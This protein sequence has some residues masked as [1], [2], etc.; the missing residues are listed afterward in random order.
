[1]A[2]TVSTDLS[3]FI[4]EECGENVYECYQCER[5][6]SGCPTVSAMRYRPAQMMRLAQFGMEQVLEGKI[7]AHNREETL[8][9][10]LDAKYVESVKGGLVI[11]IHD[12]VVRK[13]LNRNLSVLYLHDGA[14]H[15]L[16]FSVCSPGEGIA[17]KHFDEHA[18]IYA[19]AKWNKLTLGFATE[20]GHC[21]WKHT[22]KLSRIIQRK[23]RLPFTIT[24]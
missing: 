5:C 2:I 17:R 13:V 23:A 14:V 24:S 4:R 19:R 9:T 20:E 7:P 6:S 16:D 3:K 21:D 8:G 1:M 10:V 12:R 11:V 18:T 22:W 15:Q